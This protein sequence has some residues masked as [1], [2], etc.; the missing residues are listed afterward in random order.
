MNRDEWRIVGYTGLGHGLV[1]AVEVTFFALLLRIEVAFGVDKFFLG[2]VATIFALASGAT[3]LPAG[4]LADR[5]GTKRTLSLSFLAAALTATL[6]GLAPNQYALAGG[7][8][9]LGL[10]TGLYHPPGI[11]LI[12]HSVR[13]RARAVGYHGVAGNL[14]IAAAPLL[15][16]LSAAL[17]SW[18]L[19]YFSLAALALV[20]A[21]IIQMSRLPTLS[22]QEDALRTATAAG[23]IPQRTS[24]APLLLVYLIS[25]LSGFIYRGSLTFMP[26]HIEENLH[27][28]VFGHSGTEVAGSLTS[29]AL[30]TG[31]V[32]QYVGGTLSSRF[33]LESLGLALTAFIVP[34]LF[35]VGIGAGL[36]LLL[37]VAAFIFF[38][39]AAQP[40]YT[41]L[42]ASYTAARA[43]G[44]SYG[45]TFLVSLTVGSIAATPAGWIAERWGTAAVYYLMAAVAVL[46]LLTALVIWRLATSHAPQ[47]TL[48]A[49][50]D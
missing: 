12:A 8:V 26:A 34:T 16:G 28:S 7:L 30:L 5:I 24:L 13:Q 19:A 35:L 37:A 22:D 10:T 4:F 23:H 15:A 17:I 36:A 1:H 33:R 48:P 44:R 50:A 11:A 42:V 31:M 14:G 6:V 49:T 18:R 3:A 9:L 38:Y 47:A 41:S 2:A 29:L 25:V 43:I 39:F 40:M 20:L 21:L 45:V 46:S 27:V 32:G